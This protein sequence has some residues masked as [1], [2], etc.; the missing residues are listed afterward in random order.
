MVRKYI[1]TA[2]MAVQEK[3][4]GGI[5]YLLPD[6]VM[7][8][9]YLVPLMFIWKTLTESGYQA[10]MSV[11]QLLSYT[12]VNALLTDM[13]TVNTY[14]TAWNYD[15]RSAEMFTRPLPV[16]GQVISRTL[17]KWGPMLLLFSLPM[18]LAA[19]LLG[20]RILPGTPWAIP[21]LVLSVSLGFALEF[22]FFCVTIRLRNVSWPVYVIRK[23]VVSFFSG[24]VIPFQILPFGL[25]RWI[26]YQPFGSMGGAFLSL[27]VGSA[28][29]WEVIPVQI[30]WN[31]VM[32]AW[33]VVWFRRSR[34]R[35]V[36]FGG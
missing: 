19:P 24:T 35:M 30:F 16:F 12:Y 32:W 22:V 7:K 17:G 27:Y 3:T 29:A 11:S 25:E 5:L 20:I 21:S 36:S 14:L 15:T 10:E 26:R 31:L 6:I 9:I 2:N 34:E 23:A 1:A 4:G 8:V 18:F 13:M 33:A 28:K